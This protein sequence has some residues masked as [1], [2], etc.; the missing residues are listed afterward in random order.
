MPTREQVLSALATTDH[1]YEAAARLVGVP[2]G[3]AYMIATG[4]PA[5][6]G[7]TFPPFALDRPGV[8]SGSTQHLVYEDQEVENA[9][10]KPHVHEWLKHKALMDPPLQKAG[11]S[12][13]AAPGAPRDTEETDVSTVLTRDHDQVVAMFEELKTIPG[14]T[15]G[16]SEVH[17]SRRESLV[18]M[19]SVAL[20]QHES[21]E[22]EYF[23]PAVRSTLD[24]GDELADQA[25]EQEQEGKNL[26]NALGPVSGS[27]KEFDEL[28]EQLEKAARKHVAFEDRVLMALRE[29]MSEEDR[30]ELGRKIQR[31]ERHAPTRPHPHAP[32][33]PAPAVKAAGAAGAAMD[34]LRDTVGDRPAK[35]RGRAEDEPDVGETT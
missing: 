16:G 1:N 21:S 22:Q 32:K 9:T 14:V 5:D 33:R 8:L 25:L 26:L 28:Q 15:K 13:D 29:V 24:N 2:P 31:A 11:R 34:K 27:E 20:S 4:L 12:R 6:G 10:T 30:R 7:D 18:D 35:R 23:W 17:Q 19:I 3:Q